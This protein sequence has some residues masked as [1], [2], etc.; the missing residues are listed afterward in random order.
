[1]DYLN[2]D[3]VV[4]W[5]RRRERKGAFADRYCRDSKT[6]RAFSFHS[7]ASR[8]KRTISKSE[9][10]YTADESHCCSSKVFFQVLEKGHDSAFSRAISDKNTHFLVWRQPIVTENNSLFGL[11]TCL[12]EIRGQCAIESVPI[13]KERNA[14]VIVETQSAIPMSLTVSVSTHGNICAV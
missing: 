5:K 4:G 8:S 1:M 10:N 6:V 13:D 7:C 14:V 11:I 9:N 12:M 2:G 3:S